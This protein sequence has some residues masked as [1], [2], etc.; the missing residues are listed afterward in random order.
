MNTKQVQV[1]AK[2]INKGIPMKAL[3][4]PS[5]FQKL[6]GNSCGF[7][8]VEMIIVMALF[9]FVIAITGDTFNRIVSRS[10]FLSRT[11]ESNIAGIIG[12]EIM[13]TDLESAGYG[14][15]SSF[16]TSINY[17]EAADEPG[18]EMNDNVRVYA[19]DTDGVQSHVPRAIMSR[20]DVTSADIKELLNGTDVLAI[21]SQSVATN[22]TSKRWTYVESKVLPERNPNAA[23]HQ[24]SEGGLTNTDKVIV[25]QSRIVDKKLTNQL[26]VNPNDSKWNATFNNYSTIGKPPTYSDADGHSDTY[27]I[28]GVNGDASISNLR[29]PFNRADYYVRRPADTVTSAF[30]VPER[31]HPASGILFKGVIGHSGGHYQEL[32]LLECVLDMQVVFGRR[33]SDSPNVT[34]ENDISSLTPSEVR[35]QIKEVKIYILTHAG[36]IDKT[37]TYPNSTIGVGPGD[38]LTSGTGRTYNLAGL[39]NWQNYRWKVYQLTARPMNLVGNVS[40]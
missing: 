11:A 39:A 40:Q 36:S 27:I 23:P 6:Y 18:L 15:L 2:L 29:M 19:T 21:R 17:S 33:G 37:Y 24:W 8:L 38:G 35:E 4:K 5:I 12:L 16:A 28:Y 1:S 32:P 22:D 13:R 34:F 31:C 10:T 30:R 14:L 9:I 7:T 26:I 20:N 25:V 3:F